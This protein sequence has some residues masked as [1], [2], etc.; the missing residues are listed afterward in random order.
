MADTDLDLEPADDAPP[1][2][3]SLRWMIWLLAGIVVILVALTWAGSRNDAGP[4]DEPAFGG[5]FTLVAPDGSAVT[6]ADIA[7]KPFAIYFGFTRCPDVCPT[8]L[9]SLA[10]MRKALG[11]DGDRFRIVFVSVDPGHDKPAAIGEYVSLFE[12]PILGLTGSTAQ[13]EQIEQGFGVY[14]KQVPQ[15]GGDYTIDHTAAVFLID[16]KGKLAGTISH[17]EPE[18]TGIEK[19]RLMLD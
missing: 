3:G 10:R 2:T 14:V 17:G 9:A 19:L 13:L 12:T 4:G 5:D 7:D 15:P 11:T 6:R 18:K 8:T 1:G 16:A